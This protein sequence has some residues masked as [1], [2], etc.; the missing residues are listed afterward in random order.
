M[1]LRVYRHRVNTVDALCATPCDL[2]VECDLRADGDRVILAHD[3]FT[4]GPR[5]EEYLP[6]VGPRPCI[7]NIKCEGI[8]ERV[9]A[10]AAQH[11]VEDFFL[12][13]V[14]VPA[15][16]RLLR[17]GEGRMAVRW[18]EYEPPELA[19]RWRGLARWLWV[20]CFTAWPGGDD[21]WAA[22]AQAFSVC[23][24]SPEL[25]GH[26]TETIGTRRATLG[27]RPYHAV[28]T[29]RPDLWLPGYP[30]A[31]SAGGGESAR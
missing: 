28:C 9:L 16:V 17:R 26:G 25:Q 2:G 24:V 5:L 19:L 7:F 15:A 31:P 6:H 1:G 22:V 21:A 20:D 12:L 8:E 29:K 14:G 27:S 10:L 23:L 30:L 18:S 11:R 4:G 3:P 13:D